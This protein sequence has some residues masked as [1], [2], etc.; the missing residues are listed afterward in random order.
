MIALLQ[1]FFFLAQACQHMWF[2]ILRVKLDRG[3]LPKQISPGRQ[4]QSTSRNQ[5][6]GGGCR[7]CYHIWMSYS[8]ILRELH[9]VICIGYLN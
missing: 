3:L 4:V 1:H 5:N 8:Q 2:F 6:A 9:F 7:P